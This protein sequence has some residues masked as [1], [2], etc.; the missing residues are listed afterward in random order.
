M[1]VSVVEMLAVAGGGAIGCLSRYIIGQ[2]H[3]FQDYT[4]NT[5]L[6]NLAGCLLIGILWVL[7]SDRNSALSSSFLITG[8][9]GGF[10]TFSTFALH[11]MIMLRDGE[12][13][14]ALF[15][16]L[17]TVVGGLAACAL[18]IIIAEKLMK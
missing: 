15:Y 3:I 11:P 8:I 6:I 4:Y 18:G 2:L 1:S 7:L 13:L 14:Q 17:T 10:T 16:V 9:L 12:Y 5:I